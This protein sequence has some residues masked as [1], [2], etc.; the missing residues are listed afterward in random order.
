MDRQV[1]IAFSTL[2]FC[3]VPHMA[4]PMVHIP[5]LAL[6]HP[7]NYNM[8]IPTGWVSIRAASNTRNI[9]ADHISYDCAD[10][11]DSEKLLQIAIS[12]GRQDAQRII[13]YVR[14]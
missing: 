12:I 3:C 4:Y 6:S 1:D 9:N 5:R 7:Y 14:D 8:G 10:E 13:E 2:K 11:A